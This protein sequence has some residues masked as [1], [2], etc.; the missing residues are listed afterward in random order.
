MV[1]L[2]LHSGQ[3]FI[4]DSQ[5]IPAV[6]VVEFL[7]TFTSL[8]SAV[9]TSSIL[10]NNNQY[11]FTEFSDT[12]EPPELAEITPNGKKYLYIICVF[13][14]YLSFPD[15]CSCAS[16]TNS[17]NAPESQTNI[18]RVQVDSCFGINGPCVCNSSSCSVS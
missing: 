16:L 10:S 14:F 8:T 3:P 12:V 15:I 9:V 13:L 6:F 4:E 5:I 7:S 17:S 11:S 2:S 1:T 18:V